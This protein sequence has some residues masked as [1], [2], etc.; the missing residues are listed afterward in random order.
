MI[1]DVLRQENMDVSAQ[2][3]REFA[4]S[5]LVCSILATVDWMVPAHVGK[6][7]LLYPAY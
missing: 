4:F 3:E 5:L 1:A 6:A 2:K 7:R